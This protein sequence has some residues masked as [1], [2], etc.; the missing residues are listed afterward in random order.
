VV[1]VQVMLH[2]AQENMDPA[3]EQVAVVKIMVMV[4]LEMEFLVIQAAQTLLHHLMDGVEMVDLDLLQHMVDQ[5]MLEEAAVVPVVM[6]QL[7]VVQEIN[8]DL[9]EMV[10]NIR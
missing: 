9:V 3:V 4:V 1:A 5:I 6:A 10:L 7:V 8:M 2:L